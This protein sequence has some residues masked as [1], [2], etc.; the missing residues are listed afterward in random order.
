ML[1]KN[2]MAIYQFVFFL[3]PRSWVGSPEFS[4]GALFNE[5]GY[6]DTNAAWKAYGSVSELEKRFSSIFPENESGEVGIRIWGEEA[7]NDIQLFYSG[8]VV[9]A[10]QV[11]LDKR[12][13]SY[14]SLSDIVEVSKRVKC[15]IFLPRKKI[16]ID[17]DSTQLMEFIKGEK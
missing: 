14:S 16:V 10:V 9:E 7:G 11:R 4:I 1:L 6:V 17:P 8:D 2:A 13:L 5:E 12:N 15:S 3:V